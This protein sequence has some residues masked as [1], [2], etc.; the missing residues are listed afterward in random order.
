MI[1]LGKCLPDLYNKFA[2]PL[3]QVLEGIFRNAG[4]RS[5]GGTFLQ[6]LQITPDRLDSPQVVSWRLSH[7]PGSL[8]GSEDNTK[9]DV[10]W[11]CSSS[12]PV[13]HQDD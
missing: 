13:I 3:A 9:A 6:K 12:R 10:A 8:R 1:S 11:I 5:G 4:G 2:K 7:L